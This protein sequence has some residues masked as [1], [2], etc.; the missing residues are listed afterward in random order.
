GRQER[1]KR[2]KSVLV[3]RLRLAGGGGKAAPVREKFSRSGP[4]F[5]RRLSCIDAQ[6]HRSVSNRKEAW[7]AQDRHPGRRSGGP[8]RRVPAGRARARGIR[9]PGGPPAR[10]RGG[11]WRGE[12]GRGAVR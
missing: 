1:S 11:R 10:P 7:E 9:R 5:P 6:A 3:R 4:P 8:R 2:R 12:G